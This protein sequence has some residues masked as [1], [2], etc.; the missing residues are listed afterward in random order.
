MLEFARQD[1][2]GYIETLVKR[3]M[4]I[5]SGRTESHLM[6]VDLRAKN[7]TGRDAEALL[8]EVHI[9]VNKNAIPFDQNPPMVASGIRTFSRV[10]RIPESP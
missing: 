9:T 4:R 6:L 1:P 5:V 2:V 3:G 8:G 7:I 10:R